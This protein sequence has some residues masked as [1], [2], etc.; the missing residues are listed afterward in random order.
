MNLSS[1]IDSLHESFIDELA[2]SNLPL[3]LENINEILNDTIGFF[4]HIRNMTFIPSIDEEQHILSLKEVML[5]C[6]CYYNINYLQP[7]WDIFDSMLDR[8]NFAGWS[9]LQKVHNL[10]FIK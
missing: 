1:I 2:S 3:S 8:N 7:L 5:Y 6:F 9:E 10:A 4:N